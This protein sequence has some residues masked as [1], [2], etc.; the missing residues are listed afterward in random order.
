[1]RWLADGS[2]RDDEDA[3]DDGDGARCAG[4]VFC[5]L[6]GARLVE[7][8][9]SIV[10][11]STTSTAAVRNWRGRLRGRRP[12]NGPKRSSRTAEGEREEEGEWAEE[13]PELLVP[14]FPRESLGHDTPELYRVLL[15]QPTLGERPAVRALVFAAHAA[16]PGSAATDRAGW[17]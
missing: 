10:L 17:W 4:G 3:V 11:T 6:S 14:L 5:G 9:S 8:V 12:R 15:M 16:N 1:M 2:G 7:S 13:N